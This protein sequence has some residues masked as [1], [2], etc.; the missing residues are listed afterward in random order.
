MQPI[1]RPEETIQK[2]RDKKPLVH[3]ITNWV[4]ISECASMT[5]ATGAL[6][7]MAHAI[8][9]KIAEYQPFRSR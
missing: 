8:E 4:T 9:G 3:H 5:R 1:E 7:V 2:V 6:P